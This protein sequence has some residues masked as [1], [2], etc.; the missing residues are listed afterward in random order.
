MLPRIWLP[1]KWIILWKISRFRGGL[2]YLLT[3]LKMQQM[4]NVPLICCRCFAV[5]K[6]Y[7]CHS[8][9]F[10]LWGVQTRR[11]RQLAWIL[12]SLC[13]SSVRAY[14]YTIRQATNNHSYFGL[15]YGFRK[16]AHR[17]LNSACICASYVTYQHLCIFY[18]LARTK[19]LAD[20]A[21]T[22]REA[23]LDSA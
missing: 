13:M 6:T 9:C 14:H 1:S 16:S 3:D 11:C 8:K 10:S 17:Y 23:E 20:T 4:H 12:L 21:W 19:S 22:D 2:N 7:C 5:A 18:N 15:K